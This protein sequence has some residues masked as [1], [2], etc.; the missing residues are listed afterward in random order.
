MEPTDKDMA[1]FLGNASALKERCEYFEMTLNKY[2]VVACDSMMKQLSPENDFERDMKV[3]SSSPG[4][5]IQMESCKRASEEARKIACWIRGTIEVSLQGEALKVAQGELA[6]ASKVTNRAKDVVESSPQIKNLETWKTDMRR[7]ENKHA[8][9][10]DAVE[11]VNLEL[12]MQ[13]E[14]VNKVAFNPSDRTCV[15][16]SGAWPY[17]PGA[18]WRL[19]GCL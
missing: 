11:A 12:E 15:T 19:L 5:R 6:K 3:K 16:T 13:T 17:P 18:T 9:A 14:D 2:E 4:D 8:E 7:L 1:V 10:E